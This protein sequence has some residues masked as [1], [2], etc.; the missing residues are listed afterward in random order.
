MI[1]GLAVAP[2]AGLLHVARPKYTV[3]HSRPTLE[4]WFAAAPAGDRDRAWEMMDHR[5]RTL[6]ID[7]LTANPP[8]ARWPN[9]TSKL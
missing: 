1:I 9:A 8:W 3:V 5:Q 6:C 7:Y 4:E 2:V